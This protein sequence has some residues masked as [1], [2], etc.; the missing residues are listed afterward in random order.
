MKPLTIIS[1]TF[2]FLPLFGYSR[3]WQW[4]PEL[5][6]GISHVNILLE[7]LWVVFLNQPE[8]ELCGKSIKIS[9]AV[10]RSASMQVATLYSYQCHKFKRG[11]NTS[12]PWLAETTVV[13]G[14]VCFVGVRGGTVGQEVVLSEH[15][16]GM[17]VSY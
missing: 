4:M 3:I 14:S 7:M 5:K 8:Y 12:L 9:K 17:F 13:H 16:Y 2:F 15:I 11:L 10:S 6:R 1:Q